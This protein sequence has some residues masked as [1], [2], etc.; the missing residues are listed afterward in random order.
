MLS[1]YVKGGDRIKFQLYMGREVDGVVRAILKTTSGVRLRVEYG[2][3]LATIH[4]DQ[5]TWPPKPLKAPD[6]VAF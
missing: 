1:T 3:N 6:D 5:I 2:R 4:P